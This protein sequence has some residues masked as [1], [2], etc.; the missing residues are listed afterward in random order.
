MPLTAN[1]NDNKDRAVPELGIP[2]VDKPEAEVPKD[3]PAKAAADATTLA[4][5][6]AVHTART[7]KTTSKDIR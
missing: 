4:Q 7:A 5:T 3:K 1:K 6:E 2:P